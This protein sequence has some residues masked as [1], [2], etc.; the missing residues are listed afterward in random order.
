MQIPLRPRDGRVQ[1]A[2]S[3]ASLLRRKYEA[4]S[5]RRPKRRAGG[6]RG[7]DLGVHS[8]P[9]VAH[10][11]Y[12]VSSRFLSALGRD[13]SAQATE[14]GYGRNLGLG[15]ELGDPTGFTGK[16]WVGR[17]N[18]IDFGVGFDGYAYRG[19]CSTNH[20]GVC[21]GRLTLNADYL[22]QSN[23]VKNTA[24]L[25][26]HLGAGGRLNVWNDNARNYISV[27][28]RMPVGVDLMFANPNF[29]VFLF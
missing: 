8:G 12:Y 4:L 10:L 21:N 16:S 11:Q 3:R 13:V 29:L 28:G 6:F 5:A 14:V 18:A 19:T 20:A 23:L 24:Q 15:F 1:R 22:W 17:T 26:W 2:G 27:G 25:D 9:C 7:Q